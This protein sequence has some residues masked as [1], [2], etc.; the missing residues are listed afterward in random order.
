MPADGESVLSKRARLA[1]PRPIKGLPP[2]DPATDLLNILKPHTLVKD[3]KRVSSAAGIITN[4]V[5]KHPK[6]EDPARGGTTRLRAR[7]PPCTPPGGSISP[8]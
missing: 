7:N 4:S 1:G 2:I 3:N 6:N 5:Q 8:T